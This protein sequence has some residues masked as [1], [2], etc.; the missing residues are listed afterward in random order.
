M[1]VAI[2][3]VLKSIYN[4]EFQ[5]RSHFCP[6]RG[7]HSFLRRNKEEWGTSYRFLKFDRGEKGPYSALHS[8]LLSALPGHIYL[9]KPNHEIGRIRQ[10]YKIPIVQRIRSILLRIGH[11]DDQ[12]SLPKKKGE[13]PFVFHPSSALTAFVNKPSSLICASFFI[14][15]V[16]FTHKFEFYGRERC[17]NNWAMRDSIK[18]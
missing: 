11:I 6:G 7:F 5:D 4:L 18:Y 15:A 16:G 14:E 3:I 8:V 12:E 1:K 2:K 17:N 13:T 9:H 10:K